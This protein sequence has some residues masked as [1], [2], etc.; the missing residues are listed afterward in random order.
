MDILTCCMP[1][2]LNT[3]PTI[4]I[5]SSKFKLL[6]ILGEGSYSIVYLVESRYNKNLYA[7]KKI[8]TI[9]SAST[10]KALNEVSYYKQ[11]KS[12]YIISAID[13]SSIQELDGSRS[14]YILLPYFSNGSLQDLI[15][16]TIFDNNL[17]M[18]EREILEI[19]ASICR[20]VLVL[21]TYHNSSSIIEGYSDNNTTE[22][23]ET[24][25]YAHYDLKPENIFISKDGNPVIG[26]L[27]SCSPARI[28]I[29]NRAEAISFQ[30]LMA[31]NST[32]EFRA[33][34]LFDVKV[35]TL[36][37][38]RVDVWSLGCILYTMLYGVNPFTR[39]VN[40]TG[41]NMK[42][43]IQSGKW[44][45]PSISEEPSAEYSP[46]CVSLISE[47]LIVDPIQRPSVDRLLQRVL[48]TLD[49]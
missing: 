39:E 17:R 20:G 1:C 25:P 34:E 42:L 7:L 9:S 6:N 36:F 48:E 13:S 35:N 15:N 44:S 28:D 32:P 21:H 30:E 49:T 5:N 10:Q 24:I 41:A 3:T 11:F 47:A 40:K 12:P 31:E 19:F 27:G 45:L 23:S 22:M 4:S 8:R 2:L 26:D 29:T 18:S 16:S 43:A 33:P 14:I 37:D 46:E 38:E